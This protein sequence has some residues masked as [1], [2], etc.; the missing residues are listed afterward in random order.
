[1]TPSGEIPFRITFAVL[2]VTYFAMRLFFQKRI[3]TSLTYT[4]I[5][6]QQE[7]RLFRLFAL[8]FI[9]LPLYFLTLWIDFAALPLPLWLRWGGAIVTCLGIAL[10]GWAHQALGQNWTA[11]LALS[12]EHEFVQCGLYRSVRHPMYAAFFI[13]GIGFALLSANL[14]VG[15]IYLA[16]LS[17]MY[18]ARVSR[19][20]Q[21]MIERFGDAYREYM[22]RTGRLWPRVR[23]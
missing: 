18:V 4:R 13:I 11:V 3:K 22:K 10:F 16:P 5:N 17:V 2:W 1:M 20:E 14:L 9:L 8:A 7:T 15:V 21:M 19:E 12:Q 23:C 6:V